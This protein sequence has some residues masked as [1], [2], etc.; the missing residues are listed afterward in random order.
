MKQKPLVCLIDED[1]FVKEGW[2]RTLKN[3][4]TLHYFRDHLGV[5]KK[6]AVERNL[7]SSYSCI[8]MSRFFQHLNLDIT[9]SAIPETLR[10][11]GSGPIFLNWQGYISKD[12]LARKF[13]GKLF[14]KYGV[15]WQTLRLRIQKFDKKNSAGKQ[16]CNDW[17]AKTSRIA[18]SSSSIVSKPERCSAL[19]RTMAQNAHGNH[20]EKI[21]FYAEHDPVTG[22]ALLEAIY[23]KLVTDKNRPESCP[24]RYI[25]SSPV[26]AKRILHEALFSHKNNP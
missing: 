4:A 2:A 21:E 6:A 26:I 5:F 13:D 7:I 9:N 25:N 20:R 19:L 8:I 1:S 15:R 16:V 17:S 3:D 22:I 23:N 11:S 18:F 12:D 24:S 10:S 14:H